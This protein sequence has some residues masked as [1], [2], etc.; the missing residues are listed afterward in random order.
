M[1]KFSAIIVHAD[2]T[3]YKWLMDV[4][5]WH[6]FCPSLELYHKP[7]AIPDWIGILNASNKS[8]LKAR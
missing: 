1:L 8:L 3:D 7:T 6:D 5:S 4:E 2:Y